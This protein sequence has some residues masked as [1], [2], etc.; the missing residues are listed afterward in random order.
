VI[1]RESSGLWYNVNGGYMNKVTIELDDF[2]ADLIVD[3]LEGMD[4]AHVNDVASNLYRAYCT[5][6]EI[7][8]QKQT[9]VFDKPS[10]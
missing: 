6:R 4:A 1:D 10:S 8:R 9:V 5:A 3:F 2:Q 7:W